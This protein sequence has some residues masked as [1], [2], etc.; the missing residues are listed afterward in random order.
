MDALIVMADQDMDWELDIEEFRNC[1]D[2]EV[3]PPK[4]REFIY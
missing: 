3:D 4:K 1:L 2:P